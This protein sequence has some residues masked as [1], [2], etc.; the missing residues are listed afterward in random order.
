MNKSIQTKMCIYYKNS[1]FLK[2]ILHITAIS[3]IFLAR[4]RKLIILLGNTSF[5]LLLRVR[6]EMRSE[7][8]VCEEA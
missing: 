5:S 8:Y 2:K 3:D 6:I 4:D 1:D 7:K